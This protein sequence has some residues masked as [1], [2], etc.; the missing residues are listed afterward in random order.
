MSNFQ[1][2]SRHKSKRRGIRRGCGAEKRGFMA[3]KNRNGFRTV[4][5][6]EA[7]EY[8]K[9]IKA[10]RLKI[11]KRSAV[12][13]MILLLLI[14]GGAVFMTFRQY[15]DF[16]VISSVR[17]SDT[18]A[19]RFDEF[20]GNILK[21]SNDGAFY[22]DTENSLIWNQTYEM[23]NPQLDICEQYLAIYDKNGTRI[24]IL[25]KEG[26]QGSIETTMPIIQV[27]VAAQGTVAVLMEKGDNAFVALYDRGGNNLASGEIHGEQGGYPVAIALS[28]DAIKLAVSML[29]VNDGNVKSMVAFYNY[30]SVGQN[31][32]DNC[33][34][35][36]SF[37]DSVIPELKYTGNDSMV[38][39]GDSEIAIFEGAQKPQLVTEIPFEKEIRSIFYSENYVGLVCD[40][41]DEALTKH[42]VVYS[43]GGN[44]VMEK[45]FAIDYTNIEFLSNDEVCIRNENT[46]DIYTLRG[47]HKFHYEFD[48]TLYRVLPGVSGLNYTFV[49]ND[50]TEKV[51]LK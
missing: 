7:K 37:A 46:C 14:L 47:V 16:D 49:L 27:R 44:V 51:R 12:A 10:H 35:A 33:V 26:L 41:E 17:R 13:M 9:K 34:G 45:D 15:D 24:Y 38:A 28:H 30:S 19:T 25:T 20:Q 2:N 11:L 1:Y 4:G 18:M 22:L 8:K 40:N 42:L 5:E 6:A 50:V 36:V 23:S 39:F 48:G 32:I 21:Y 43:I 3:E 29:N 31:E